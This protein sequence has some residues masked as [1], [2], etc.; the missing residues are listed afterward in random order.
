MIRWL[1]CSFC[2][3]RREFVQASKSC[4]WWRCLKCDKCRKAQ[5][6]SMKIEAPFHFIAPKG[7]GPYLMFVSVW[8]HRFKFQGWYKK[9]I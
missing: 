3:K 6:G 7:D 1:T 4:K 5:E 8:I 9:S 2:G